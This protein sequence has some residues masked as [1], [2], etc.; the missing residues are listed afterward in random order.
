MLPLKILFELLL[1][2][3][4]SGHGGPGIG[5]HLDLLEQPHLVIDIPL[6]GLIKIAIETP[7]LVHGSG[8]GTD[9]LIHPPKPLIQLQGVI[10]LIDDF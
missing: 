4:L 8:H 6:L 7:I 5:I 3:V 1:V 9:H 2:A 10:A